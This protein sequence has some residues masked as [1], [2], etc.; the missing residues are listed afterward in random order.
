MVKG[1]EMIVGFLCYSW[2]MGVFFRKE[3]ER[4]LFIFGNEIGCFLIRE[5]EISL[6]L[7]FS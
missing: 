7:F 6:G 3:L 2:F 4:L 1:S 5:S